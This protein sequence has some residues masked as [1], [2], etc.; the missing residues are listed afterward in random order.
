MSIPN[1]YNPSDYEYLLRSL[2]EGSHIAKAESLKRFQILANS[3]KKQFAVYAKRIILALQDQFHE[4][5]V[6]FSSFRNKSIFMPLCS[7][8]KSSIS[9]L[10]I[11]STTSE[12]KF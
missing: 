9:T 5:R 11:S 6:L 4:Q 7:S 2:T 12:P 10:K 3:D 1:T 8:Y